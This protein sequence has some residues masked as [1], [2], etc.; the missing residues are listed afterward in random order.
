M[1]THN[2]ALELGLV[3][4]LAMTA[5][6]FADPPPQGNAP[7][8]EPDTSAQQGRPPI[9]KDEGARH[10]DVKKRE[11][12]LQVLQLEDATRAQLAQRL[13]QLDQKTEDLLKQ[14]KEAF[15]ALREQAKGLRKE[16]RRGQRGDRR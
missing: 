4:A 15:L 16:P 8:S 2:L 10:F 5:P 1:R 11:R 6:V 7:V 14:R 3:A 9:E 12:L 13:E